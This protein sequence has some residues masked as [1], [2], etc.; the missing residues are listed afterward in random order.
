MFRVT[1]FVEDKN[2]G[3]SLQL[4][5][6]LARGVSEVQ[7]V[8][9]ATVRN[10]KLVAVSGGTV[11]EQF[12]AYCKHHKLTQFRRRELAEF[13]RT[14]GRGPNAAGSLVTNML[15]TGVVSRVGKGG[16][17]TVL[18]YKINEPKK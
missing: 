7:P 18:T 1:Y 16:T 15:K 17:G 9:N 3:Q 5:Q 11:P 8:T 12:L 14:I 4:L 13:C 2:L 10:G 6:G